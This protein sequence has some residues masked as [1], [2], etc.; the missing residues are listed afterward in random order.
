ME[1][2]AEYEIVLNWHV[3]VSI[4]GREIKEKVKKYSRSGYCSP[5]ITYFNVSFP[6]KNEFLKNQ[7]QEVERVTEP[8]IDLNRHV[9][10]SIFGREI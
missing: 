1:R 9:L 10:F 4:F 6:A 7:W 8:K 3:F 2:V 5:S